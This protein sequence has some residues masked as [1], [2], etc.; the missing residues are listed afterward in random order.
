MI[1]GKQKRYCWSCCL[2]GRGELFSM[3]STLA[4]STRQS[5]C[6]GSPVCI[7]EL[8]LEAVL[9]LLLHTVQ[10]VLLCV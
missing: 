9:A 7:L 1:L 10:L 5:V 2:A 4:V 8:S 6:L 3:P